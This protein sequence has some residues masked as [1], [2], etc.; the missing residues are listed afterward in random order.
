MRTDNLNGSVRRVLRRCLPLLLSVGLVRADIWDIDPKRKNEIRLHKI[1]RWLV[2]ALRE[3]EIDLW[4]VF[5]RDADDEE[6][7]VVWKDKRDIRHDS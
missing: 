3:S 2:P 6:V 5:L 7:N 4:L 1:Q